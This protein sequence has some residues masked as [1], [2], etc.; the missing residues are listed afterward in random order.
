MPQENERMVRHGCHGDTG[1]THFEHLRSQS[2]CRFLQKMKKHNGTETLSQSTSEAS[3]NGTS[4]SPH[5]SISRSKSCNA[6][7]SLF[8][9]SVCTPLNRVCTS[10]EKLDGSCFLPLNPELFQ[11]LMTVR[12]KFPIIR[13]PLK[14]CPTAG[15]R[16]RIVKRM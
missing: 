1:F 6:V 11:Q 9:N 16:K 14:C 8:F 12:S 3:T 10:L 7:T 2:C 4:S 15:H 5:F 13:L